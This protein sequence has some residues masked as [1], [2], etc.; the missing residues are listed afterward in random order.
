[1]IA[2]SF[3]KLFFADPF[4]LD[5]CKFLKQQYKQVVPESQQSLSSA[6]DFHIVLAAFHLFKFRQEEVTE[7]DDVNVPFLNVTSCGIFFFSMQICSLNIVSVNICFLYLTFLTL[8]TFLL[9][10]IKSHQYPHL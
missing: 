10:S 7:V 3:H 9:H 8:N 2:N 4:G 5:V 6:S 1:M